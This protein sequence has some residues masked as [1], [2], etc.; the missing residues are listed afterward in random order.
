MLQSILRIM[1][2]TMLCWLFKKG[3]DPWGFL[4]YLWSLWDFLCTGITWTNSISLVSW[5]VSVFFC[6][7]MQCISQLFILSIPPN[8]SRN[9]ILISGIYL[10]WSID[11]FFQESVGMR[12]SVAYVHKHLLSV[13]FWWELCP[14][15]ITLTSGQKI[16]NFYMNISFVCSTLSAFAIPQ[17][18]LLTF[19]FVAKKA[20]FILIEL[21]LLVLLKL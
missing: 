2:E 9:F 4:Q 8:V 3:Y 11:L 14:I 15:Q 7:L 12:L 6:W 19:R 18:A 16:K 17:V 20:N 1:R 5:K 10:I 13:T 21:Q